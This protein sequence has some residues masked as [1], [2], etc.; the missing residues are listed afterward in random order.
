VGCRQTRS[1]ASE[2]STFLDGIERRASLK[3]SIPWF[4][5]DCDGDLDIVILELNHHPQVLIGDLAERQE[6]RWL[7]VALT[8]TT[9]NRDGLS[10]SGWI[11]IVE[12]E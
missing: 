9:S 5:L 4:D 2:L 7:G 11:E 1:L 12:P 10:D 8:G 3:P 6:V